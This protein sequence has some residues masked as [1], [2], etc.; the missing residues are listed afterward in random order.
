M[1][2]GQVG[3]GQ[4]GN[5]P[6][7]LAGEIYPDH[8]GVPG[9]RAAALEAGRLGAIHEF[10][11]AVMPQQQVVGKLTDRRRGVARVSFDRN[12]ELVLD[13]READR[14]SVVLASPLEPA[15]AGWPGSRR[16]RMLSARAPPRQARPTTIHVT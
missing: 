16:H 8:P 3:F 4:P 5:Q 12:Q 15:P 1:Q 9:V 10:N 14:G 2:F 13:V 11:R 6:V 7:T